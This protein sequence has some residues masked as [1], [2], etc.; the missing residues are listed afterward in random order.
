[1]ILIFCMC[2]FF[3]DNF[4]QLKNTWKRK[5]AHLSHSTRWYRCA[6]NTQSFIKQLQQHVLSSLL[7]PSI[8]VRSSFKHIFRFFIS[9]PYFHTNVKP[10]ACFFRKRGGTYPL[11]QSFYS[12]I[13]FSLTSIFFFLMSRK[14]PHNAQK[15]IAIL[16]NPTKLMAVSNI[17]NNPI[18]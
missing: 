11:R 7:S 4:V 17:K 9:I 15:P 16:I 1:M 13:C 18:L 3:C 2:L 8:L 5:K 6:K 14:V 10:L 12:N